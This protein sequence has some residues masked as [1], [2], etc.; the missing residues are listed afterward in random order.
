MKMIPTNRPFNNDLFRITSV[1]RNSGHYGFLNGMPIHADTDKQN[2]KFK[3]STYRISVGVYFD[4][5]PVE[6]SVGQ[7]WKVTGVKDIKR[8]DV[9]GHIIVEHTYSNAVLECSMPSTPDAFISFIVSQR[10]FKGIGEKKARALWSRF[11]ERIYDILA[12]DNDQNRLQLAEELT[13]SSV[14]YLYTGF[15]KYANL[16]H[17]NWM[18]KHDIPFSVQQ[19]LFKYHGKEAIGAI[20]N[21][22]YRLMTFGLSFEAADEL[23][24]ETFFV[25]PI[26]NRR[27]VAAIETSLQKEVGKGHTRIDRKTLRKRLSEVLDDIQLVELALKIGSE[28][29]RFVFNE[30]LNTYHP[31]G[32]LMM[33]SVVAMRLASLSKNNDLYG[34]TVSKS[35]IEAKSDLPHELMPRQYEAVISALNN[36]VACITGGAGT[37]KTTVLRI[38]LKSFH[39]QGYTIHSMALSGRAAMRMHESTGFKAKTIAAFLR[40]KPISGEKQI[41]VIDEASMVDLPM[42]YKIV[43]HSSPKVRILFVGDP[44][45]LPPI[46]AGRV[47]ADVI[48]SDVIAN[49]KLDI[50][51]RQD[52]STG[53]PEYS[54]LINQGVVPPE[55]SV[56]TITFHEV[57]SSSKIVETCRNLFKE[58]P[59]NSRVMA[60]TKKLVDKV[61]EEIQLAVNKDGEPIKFGV[62]E[63][64]T[65]VRKGDHV[66]FTKNDYK[67]DVQNGLLGVL[68]SV[69]KTMVT[70]GN[71]SEECLGVIELDDGRSVFVD[72]DIIDQVKLGYAM[73]LHRGQGSQFPRVIIALEKARNLDRAWLYTAVTRA[74]AE[75][76][77]V[78]RADVF[79]QAVINPSHTSLRNTHLS[80]LIQSYRKKIND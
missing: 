47:L 38:I 69:E 74:E 68:T 20:K 78:G 35:L 41:L 14:D 39:L 77:I 48:A 49:T 5:L 70:N 44:N 79:R 60:P 11:Q 46:G 45:Q 17:A 16:K 61:N 19:R 37:G 36:G 75:V 12:E 2:I 29:T 9:G 71:G 73:S 55:L 72:M 62:E 4:E 56:G 15:E 13:D 50:V 34:D 59:E 10:E 28:K 7:H 66:L 53:I 63:W 33:E 8:V 18:S 65:K 64:H 52:G 32:Q 51:K 21:D 42:M 23:A 43:T 24:K 1:Y 40:G 25:S 80:S 54:N 31:T 67:H 57:N 6:P 27:L 22:P 76:H 58:S 3:G 30:E 26:D